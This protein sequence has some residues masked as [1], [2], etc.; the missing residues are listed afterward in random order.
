GTGRAPRQRLE[1]HRARARVEVEHLRVVERADDVE[2]VLAHA[3]RRRPRV[4]AA[5]RVD[6]VAL[7]RAGDDPHYGIRVGVNTTS[8]RRRP[9]SATCATSRPSTPDPSASVTFHSK[10]S[11]PCWFCTGLVRCAS[12]YVIEAAI[13]SPPR[14]IS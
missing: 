7:A 6:R 5:G 2:D 8:R 10:R 9:S 12:A 3:V 13:A 11:Q 4:L 14:W 1:A